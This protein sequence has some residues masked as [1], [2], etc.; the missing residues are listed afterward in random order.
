M[1]KLLVGLLVLV[2]VVANFVY[3]VVDT[4]KLS[5][6]FD[7]GAIGRSV[8]EAHG[9][10]GKWPAGI[11]DLDGTEYLNMP[12]R[13]ELLQKGNYVIVWHQDLDPRPRANR[14]RVLA[15]DNRSLLSRFGRVW[16]VR[17]DLQVEYMARDELNELLKTAKKG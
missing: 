6:Q 10:N 9:K 14:G 4:A 1:P 5:I 2:I 15:Y 16:V 8:Y 7:L 12:Y 17:G 11:A 13:K 3:G